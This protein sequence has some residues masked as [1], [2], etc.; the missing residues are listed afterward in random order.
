MILDQD[1]MFDSKGIVF[2]VGFYSIA[3]Q[4]KSFFSDNGSESN[5]I[6]TEI[7]FPSIFSLLVLLH[8]KNSIKRKNCLVTDSRQKEAT[9]HSLIS[10]FLLHATI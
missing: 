8:C 10:C 9:I 3:I 5:E 4:S 2:R 1:E 6:S 7:L